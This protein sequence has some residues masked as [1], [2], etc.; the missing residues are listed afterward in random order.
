[1]ENTSFTL[2]EGEEGS[3]KHA[4]SDEIENGSPP[5][6]VSA[7]ASNR[8]LLFGHFFRRPGQYIHSSMYNGEGRK[9]QF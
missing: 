2:G 5:A 8:S 1:M 3:G 9:I 7:S 4:K 6:Q